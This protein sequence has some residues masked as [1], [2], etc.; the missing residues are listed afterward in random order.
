[1]GRIRCAFFKGPASGYLENGL[2]EGRKQARGPAGMLLK[3]FRGETLSSVAEEGE[4][5]QPRVT[6]W[7]ALYRPKEVYGE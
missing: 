4:G 5:G 7:R 1:M 2:Q 6:F 3:T